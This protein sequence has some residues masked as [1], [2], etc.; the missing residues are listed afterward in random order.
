M[1]ANATSLHIFVGQL[2]RCSVDVD[3]TGSPV[4]TL[5]IQGAN[6]KDGTWKD[7]PTSQADGSVSTT[8]SISAAG[9]TIFNVAEIA[10]RYL[11]VVYTFTSGTGT[12]SA[13][14]N[15]VDDT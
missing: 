4:G 13:V 7:I 10:F 5:K 14:V 1:T 8:I 2:D 15:G 3:Y 6:N 11:R 9:G 12:I